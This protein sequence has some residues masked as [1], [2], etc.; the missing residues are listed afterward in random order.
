MHGAC[1][2]LA[3]AAMTPKT[4]GTAAGDSADACTAV[5]LFR[6]PAGPQCSV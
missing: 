2:A 1:V 3:I 5:V 6:A 4:Q